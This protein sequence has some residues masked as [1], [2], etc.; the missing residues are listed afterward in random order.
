VDGSQTK[1][2]A[3]TTV[4]DL[5][6]KGAYLAQPGDLIAVDGSVLATGSGYPPRVMRNGS[7]VESTQRVYGGDRLVSRR[8]LDR[9]ESIITTD[10]AVPFKV[11]YVGEG[12]MS[13]VRDAGVPGIRRVTK[14]AASGVELSSRVMT[15][16]VNAVIARL[17]PRPGTKMVA[18]TFDD[19]PWPHQTDRILD[20]L[21]VKKVR[22]TFF[23]LGI[24]AHRQP[25][26]ARRVVEEGHVV[27]NHTLS[28]GSLAKL[29]AKEARKQVVKGRQWIQRYTGVDAVW[30]RP[31]YGAMDK[32]A[33]KI[34]RATKS[35]VV[36]WNIDS[37]DWEKGRKAKK[38]TSAVMKNAKPGAIILM[39]DGGGDREQ[40]IKALPVVIDKLKERGYTFVTIDEMYAASTR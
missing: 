11:T 3:G 35:R 30:L 13:E 8:G 21:R 1:V 6:R 27:G 29:K 28:H 22:A 17:H 36:M 10:V 2:P 31:P 23:M 20:I 26:L 5:Q 19:G 7:F 18:L 25:A 9:R 39:H 15:A 32:G 40:T 4:G 38:I 37:H 12:S 24:R 14:G 33:W 16:P 34:V